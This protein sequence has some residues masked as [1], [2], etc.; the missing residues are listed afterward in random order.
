[1]VFIK[2][3]CLCLIFVFIFCS[4]VCMVSAEQVSMTVDS[5]HVV[6]VGSGNTPFDVDAFCN[7]VYVI[8]ERQ[9]NGGMDKYILQ[10][11]PV[12]LDDYIDS[13]ID[14]KEWLFVSSKAPYNKWG[15]SGIGTMIRE[16]GRRAGVNNVHPHK[17]RRT[18][19]TRLVRK[20]MPIEQVSTILGHSNL[21]VTMRYVETDKELLKLVHK[22]HTN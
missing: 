7:V 4:V 19:A 5:K 10:E 12:S 11:Y 2:R 17:F 8:S 13:R 21:S 14:N 20:G 6:G 15:A 18:L 9:M 1:M 22:K 16:L 3:L